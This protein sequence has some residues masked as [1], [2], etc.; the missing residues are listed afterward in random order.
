MG[1]CE[2]GATREGAPQP[3]VQIQPPGTVH[4]HTPLIPSTI[5]SSIQDHLHEAIQPNLQPSRYSLFFVISSK[6]FHRLNF[7]HQLRQV[8]RLCR[9]YVFVG[10][11]LGSVG[12]LVGTCCKSSKYLLMCL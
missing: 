4:N 12:Q 8:R 3:V 9:T 6:F 7:A 5:P 11:I 10:L 1:T 2:H